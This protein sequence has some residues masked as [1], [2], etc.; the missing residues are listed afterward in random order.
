MPVFSQH[1]FFQMNHSVLS[2]SVLVISIYA[3]PPNIAAQG[4]Y[5][6]ISG[7]LARAVGA[8]SIYDQF[9]NEHPGWA[10]G[11]EYREFNHRPISLGQ[12]WNGQ[13]ELGYMFSKNFG[14]ELS[15]GF[16]QSEPYNTYATF[17]AFTVQNGEYVPTYF[18]KYQEYTIRSRSHLYGASLVL[19]VEKGP[20]VFFAKMGIVGIRS[21]VRSDFYLLDATDPYIVNE[22]WAPSESN[23]S[24]RY[25]GGMGFGSR[26][27]MG[28]GRSIGKHFSVRAEVIMTTL[29]Y[30]PTTGRLF[31]Y[32]KN[33]VDQMPIVP[34]ED[35]EFEFTDS[36]QA[37]NGTGGV[38][39]QLPFGS[40]RLNIGVV[41]HLGKN[42]SPNPDI[43]PN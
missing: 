8:G 22:T 5:F 26:G 27:S 15:W 34:P 24:W 32:E 9:I 35:R 42:S 28:V 1:P 4:V 30:S 31:S 21:L 6:G 7:G 43:L 17:F 36:T 16:A 13:G 2:L 12:G 41:F 25:S 29:S 23:Q 38:K 3:T 20:W 19:Q 18:R 10:A 39:Q 11:W 14:L 33:G 40:G 37:T